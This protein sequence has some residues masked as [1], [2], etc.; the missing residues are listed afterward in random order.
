MLV[1][2][3]CF[4]VYENIEKCICTNTKG[5]PFITEQHLSIMQ[6][7]PVTHS[8]LTHGLCMS[9]Y[10]MLL[11]ESILVLLS[12]LDSINLNSP[13]GLKKF[14]IFQSYF[15]S[16]TI[17]GI[18]CPWTDYVGYIFGEMLA[19]LYGRRNRTECCWHCLPSFITVIRFT[20]FHLCLQ[21]GSTGAL[22]LGFVSESSAEGMLTNRY[23]IWVGRGVFGFS[24]SA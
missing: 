5:I 3:V 22:K 10:K 21:K 23:G 1:D 17:C 4:S 2:T 12:L 15:P 19:N 18:C 13:F 16:V 20:I 7:R 24:T 11:G 9:L 6:Y 8:S 14:L